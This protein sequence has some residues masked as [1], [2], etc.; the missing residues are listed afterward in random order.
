VYVVPAAPDLPADAERLDVAA[1]VGVAARGPAYALVRDPDVLEG[2]PS[3]ARSVATPVESWEDYR[4]LFGGTEGPGLLPHAVAAFFAQGGRRAYVVRV[5]APPVPPHGS[6]RRHGEPPGVDDPPPGCAQFRV[7]GA[8]GWPVWARDEG[9]WGQRLTLRVRL[10]TRPLAAVVEPDGSAAGASRVLALPTGAAVLPGATLRVTAPEAHVTTTYRHVVAVRRPRPGEHGPRAVLD[11]PVPAPGD[12]AG[13]P[14]FDILEA[15]LDVVDADPARP[16]SEH[17]PALGL[18]PA[19]PRWV[20]DVVN[21]SSRLVQL[22][23]GTGP[24]LPLL[25]GDAVPTAPGE[26]P[27]ARTESGKDRWELLDLDDLFGA[28][29]AGRRGGVEAVLTAEVAV[30]VASLVVP[31]LYAPGGAPHAAADLPVE[32][33]AGFVPCGPRSSPTKVAPP[34]VELVGLR[35]DPADAE[36]LPRIVERQ[37]RVVEVAE[38]GGLVALLDVPPR[39]RPDQVLSWRG[40][41]DSSYA[42][43]YTPWVGVP[44]GAGGLVRIPPSALAAG[45]V[46]HTELVQGLARGPANQVLVGVVDVE[47]AIDTAEHGVLHQHGVNVCRLDVDGVRLTA[48]RT[49]STE[50]AWRQLTVRRLLMMLERTVRRQLQ[51]TVFEPDDGLLRDGVHRQLEGLLGTLFEQGCFAGST[52]GESYFVSTATGR[53]RARESEQ[54]RLLVEVGVAPAEP[55]EF[56]VLR[57][58]VQAEGDLRTS[59]LGTE[60]GG[61]A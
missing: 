6:P 11:T 50:A 58:A 51:W 25:D 30:E 43:C 32:V 29:D 18:A 56:V 42:A 19:H 4:D 34:P 7:G 46:A 16:R 20:V 3:R 38:R 13:E 59:V 17:H 57:V 49:L 8:H 22:P 47:R 10:T 23:P 5:V 21:T 27:V 1:F 36:D 40:C 44:D 2:E 39:L 12:Q 52:A 41:F 54:G 61:R 45:L 55:L 24:G 35:L 28:D 48:A 14:R 60:V 53:D 33:A 9:S 31:D 26:L 15:E 37:Q